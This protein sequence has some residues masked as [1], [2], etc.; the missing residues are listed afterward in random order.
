L[1]IDPDTQQVEAAAEAGASVVELHTGSYADA[2]VERRPREL[3][4]LSTAARRATKLGIE[5]HAGH[6]LHY[7]NVKPV[8][9]LP[10]ITELNIGHAIVSRAVMGGLAAAVRDMKSLM[11]DARA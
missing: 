4:R 5:V 10:E 1:F 6:G 2:G 11:L 3:E 8:A 9:A 7:G